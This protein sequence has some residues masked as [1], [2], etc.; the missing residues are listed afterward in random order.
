MF[1]LR[2]YKIEFDPWGLRLILLIMLPNLIWFAVPAPQDVLRGAS[3][4][5]AID[6]AASVFQVF[7]VAGLCGL[8]NRDAQKPARRKMLVGIGTAVAADWLGW[9][10]YYGGIANAPVIL[11]LCIAPCAAVLLFALERKNALAAG[12]AMAFLS[13]HAASAILNFIM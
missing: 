13:C 12:S 4:T 2:R 11:L 3:G 10:C 8:R 9:I 1:K 6:T 7:L 5:P